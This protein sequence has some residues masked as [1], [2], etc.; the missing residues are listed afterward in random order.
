MASSL[1]SQ[2]Y[3]M[4]TL[5]RAMGNE[6]THNVK[7]SFLFDGRQAAD[8]DTQTIFDIGRDGLY[9]L[10]QIN[11]RFDVYAETLFSESIKDMD[12]VLQ[13]K[14]ENAKLDESIRSF[15]FQLAPHFL[16][17]P[18]GKTIEWLVRRFRI[19]EFNARDV[20]AAIMPYHETKAFLTMLTII[21]FETADMDLFGFLVAQRKSRRLLD[22]QTLMAQCLRDRSL[23]A[24]V[25]QAVFRAC[26]QGLDYPGLHSFYAMVMSQYIGQLST[27]D[28]SAIQFIVPFVL[29]GLKLSSKDAQ[30][31]AYMVLGSLATRVTLT[32]EALDKVLCAV[33]QRPADVRT[34]AMCLVQ[35]LQTQADAFN[36]RL[37]VRFLGILASHSKL[38]RILCQLAESF[39]V[40]M[41]MRPL[42]SSLAHYAFTNAELSQ[43]LAALVA[44][45]PV[46]YAPTL[47]E[48]IVA[49]Y[50]AHGLEN[51]GPAEIVDIVQLCYGQQ[52]EDAIGVAAGSSEMGDREAV[53]KLLYEL[54]ARGSG[55]KSGVVLIKETAT[56][57]YLSINHADAGIRLVAAK[58]LKAIVTGE[59][60]DVELVREETSSLIVDRLA[61]DD[62]ESVL[63]VIL[64]LPLATLVN[65]QELVPALVSVIKDER[66]PI[67]KLCSKV[68]RN[69]LAIDDLQMYGQVASALF[70][71]LLKCSGT[72]AVTKAVYK[73]LPS[74]AFG[75]QKSGWLASLASAGLDNGLAAG[76]FNKS[77]A[78][79]LATEL[80]A[81]WDSLAD[82]QT[83][84][85]AAQLDSSNR[86]AR[87]TAI[88]VGAHAEALLAKAKDVSRSVAAASLVVG[89][90]LSVLLEA[91]SGAVV[92]EDVLLASVDG[93]AWTSLLASLAGVQRDALTK[94]AGGALSA[95]LSVLS[96][97]VQLKANQWFAASAAGDGSAKSQYRSLLRTTFGAIVSRAGKL[98]NSDGV[99][100]GRVLGLGMGDEWAQFLA[101]T[102]IAESSSA[103]VKSRSLISF[104]ALLRHKTAGSAAEKID[105]QTVLPSVIVA[106]GDEDARVRGAAVACVKTMHSLYPA[107]AAEKKQSSS[108]K[109]LAAGE[110]TIYRY[111]AFYGAT[112]DKLQYLPT[113][114]VAKFVAMLASRV[115]SMASD[116]WAVRNELDL[117]L[118]RGVCSGSG[119]EDAQLKLNSQGRSSVVA[120]LLSHVV[121]TDMVATGFQTR[122]LQALELVT[123]PATVLAQLYPLIGSHYGELK[124]TVGIPQQGGSEDLLVRA[125]F[126]AC[127][128]EANAQQLGELGCW[129][130]F[131]GFVAGLDSAPAEWTSEARATA[132][133]QQVAMERLMT[134]LVAAMGAAAVTDVTTCLFR[135]AVRG[136][137]YLA[138]ADVRQVAL[139]DVYAAVS[140]DAVTAADELSEIAAKLAVDD[141]DAARAGKRARAQAPDVASVLPE[142]GTLL[143]YMQCS[144]ALANSPALVPALFS[145]LNVFVSDA[146]SSTEY[147]KQ[148]V[149]GMLTRIC[150]EANAAG[151]VIPEGFM[152][153]DVI[154]QVIRTSDRPQTHN[155]TLLLLAAVAGMHPQAV[156]HNVMAIFTFMGANAVRQ[157]DEYSFHVIQQTLERVIPPVV[158]DGGAE[159]AGPVLRVF[160]DALSHI[161]RH[162]RM[163]LFSTLVRTMG[164]DVYGPAVVSLLLEKNVRRMLSRTSED[165]GKENDD[166]VS[167][168]LS[169]THELLPAQQ[170]GCAEAVV[171]DLLL[172]PSGDDETAPVG[173]ELFVD[174]AHM[175][176]RQ[177]RAYRLVALDFAHQLLTSRQF[178]AQFDRVRATPEI[179]TRLSSATS[180]LLQVITRLN[181]AVVERAAEKQAL[182]LA[183]AVLD[184]VNALM[185]RRTFV[186]TVVSLLEQSDLKIR[187]KVMALANAKLTEFNVRLVQPESSDID[188]MLA[189]LQ[190]I[191][192]IAEQASVAASAEEVACKQAALLCVATA[193]KKFAVLRPALFTGVVKAVSAAES[194]GSS[195]PAVVSA[196]L[197]ALAVL[198]NELGS[199]LI[200]SLPQY[201]P[202]VLKHLH[203]VVGRYAEAS[204]DDLTLMVAALSTMLAIVENMSAFLAPTLAPLFSCLLNPAIR[205]AP[206]GDGDVAALREQASSLTDDVL[207]AVAKCI[208]PRQLLPAQFAFYQKEASRQGAAVIVPFVAFVGR[209]ASSLQRNQLL[210]FYKPLFKFF[211]AAFDIARNPLLPLSE[212]EVIEQAT[213]D[214][215]MR[216]V[217]KLNENLFK[218]L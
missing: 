97:V 147:A 86:L 49:E 34:M 200:P 5:D 134:G 125:L 165:G 151:V 50:V 153:V 25:C 67:G 201:L 166:I 208:P 107:A 42:L 135:V 139:R 141:S 181:T 112:S 87:I 182:Q 205:S 123:S 106:L 11:Q 196:A 20:L 71:Y 75:K 24:F 158:R 186:A 163:A 95:T 23:M 214:A 43:F 173:Q 121:A 114:V 4:R 66:V 194:L 60:A 188:E 157:D 113:A 212:V 187:R 198:C 57:L 178:R 115:D 174:V 78:R 133:V 22:R 127:F 169:L 85:W 120:F 27:I 58:A 184:D 56:T 40:E 136:T 80:A 215:F 15:L 103:L 101:S 41:F 32:E 110:Q 96:S 48:R 119:K 90:A 93:S 92:S 172:L 68:V 44:V 46:S 19:H 70:P 145:L 207:A 218:P 2:L 62:S 30:A 137:A 47:C 154:V 180:T 109:S 33:A 130:A 39:N 146:G 177:L 35:V 7:A 6:R 21:T 191:A 88:V 168:A 210:Q 59:R 98:S 148:L 76:K 12:R 197:V 84:V 104:Q 155:Q 111:D 65:A 189:M 216:F 122:L 143:E 72:E 206:K 211:L 150:D 128:C 89:S 81:K 53:H 116:A 149:L 8:L 179:N 99:L 100:I 63:E 94:V 117:I 193:A 126:R 129:Q 54:K 9:E 192:A 36:S 217:V 108:R 171:R 83:G 61:Q 52:M 29:D 16:T 144:P 183:Y 195:S 159:N 203:G 132:Y 73:H 152:R 3:K 185:E 124:R 118:N 26:R 1:A 156:L 45:L 105:Y 213:L 28:N 160:V 170:I 167:F 161:P 102:W 17:K 204:A 91:D 164:V 190:P 74:S 140:L 31:A 79:V 77:V 142:L 38:P 55:N 131:M 82:A 10:R 162:R 202:Q 69:L 64:S 199:R 176:S 175:G 18:A 37:P 14:E 138:P 209:T 13:T 51:K